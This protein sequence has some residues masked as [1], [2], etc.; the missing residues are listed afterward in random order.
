MS[1]GALILM[2]IVTVWG[3]F[4]MFSSAERYEVTCFLFVVEKNSCYRYKHRLGLWPGVAS[5]SPG[6]GQPPSL[7]TRARDSEE[8]RPG[9]E[10]MALWSQSTYVPL[11]GLFST[12]RSGAARLCFWD[13]K[14]VWPAAM[15]EFFFFQSM[16][17]I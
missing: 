9:H 12:Q 7:L 3:E 11:G 8:W 2:M 4:T 10:S 16:F 14:V 13:H 5:P 1:G 6:D 15:G 17:A